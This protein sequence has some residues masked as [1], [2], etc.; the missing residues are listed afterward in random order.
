MNDFAVWYFTSHA[1]YPPWVRM[2]QSSMSSVEGLASSMNII[3]LKQ[4]IV[5]LLKTRFFVIVATC[6]LLWCTIPRIG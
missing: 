5:A 2:F 4:L 3:S 1:V 6:I